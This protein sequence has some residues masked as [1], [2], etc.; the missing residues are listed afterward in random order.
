[1]SSIPRFLQGEGVYQKRIGEYG[2]KLVVRLEQKN[3]AW[4]KDIR[5]KIIKAENMVVETC[6]GAF[7]VGKTCIILSK[8]RKFIRCEADPSFVT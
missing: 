1:M 7:S 5:R 2:F 6:A 4:V 3:T 8:H